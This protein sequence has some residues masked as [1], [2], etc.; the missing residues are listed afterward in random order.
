MADGGGWGG[1]WR[2]EARKRSSTSMSET[3]NKDGGEGR[4]LKQSSSR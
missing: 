2:S 4:G 1:S 3:S